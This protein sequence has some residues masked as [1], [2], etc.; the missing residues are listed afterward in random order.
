MPRWMLGEIDGDRE[1][2]RQIEIDT[3][4]KRI[5]PHRKST[6]QCNLE[7]EITAQIIQ[8]FCRMVQ[9]LTAM[10]KRCLNL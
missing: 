7:N 5:A 6:E 10:N 3:T 2:D 8:L 1:R 4:T 9:L